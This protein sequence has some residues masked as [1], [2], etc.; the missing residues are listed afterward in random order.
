MD[1]MGEEPARI[2]AELERLRGRVVDLE[3]RLAACRGE[4]EP[5]RPELLG[6]E[7]REWLLSKTEHLTRMGSFVWEMSN[8]ATFWSDELYRILGYEVG[9]LTP[10]AE[11]FFAIVHPDDREATR[12]LMMAATAEGVRTDASFRL[13]LR[14]GTIKHARSTAVPVVGTSGNVTSFVGAVIDITERV[15]A[16]AELRR[17]EAF[18]EEAQKIAHVGAFEWYPATGESTSSAGL[19][20]ICGLFPDE[21]VTFER[22][23]ELVHPDDRAALYELATGVEPGQPIPPHEY[24]IV[25]PDGT[26]VHAYAEGSPQYDAEGRPHGFIGAVLDITRRKAL[27]AQLLQSQK[28][29]A[30]GRLAGGV[31]HDFNNL[32]TVIGVHVALL[33]RRRQD[34]ELDEVA[35]A[36]ERAGQLTRQLLAFSRQSVFELRRVE[37]VELVR[38]S[39]RMVKRIVGEDVEIGFEAEPDVGAVSVDPSQLEQVLLNLVVNSR[40]ALPLGGHVTVRVEKARLNEPL[41]DAQPALAP[42]EYVVLEVADDGIGMD[43]EVRIRALEPFF[44]TKEPGRGTG[45]GL[46][47]VFGIVS[48]SG[49]GITLD[50]SKGVGT[51][52]RVYLPLAEAEAVPSDSDP[53]AEAMRG[54]GELLLL[55]DDDQTLGRLLAQVLED[56]G[57]RVHRTA[58]GA[59]AL[60]FFE[61]HQDEVRLVVTD[62]VMPEIGGPELVRRLRA[63]RPSLPALYVSG[64]ARESP[65][66]DDPTTR[67]AFL[68]KP[69]TPTQLI[70][71]VVEV[72]ARAR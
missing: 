38:N 8:G 34:R 12:E 68:M 11:A 31:A 19:S 25:R 47:M 64:Y 28:M 9:E 20:R 66:D 45:L 60:E 3:S 72:L 15:E 21:K 40:D 41:A 67:G 7:A 49:G 2:R 70:R 61:S 18:L 33:R 54:A 52:V 27:E 57:Y 1:D 29:E 44:T 63:R 71:R 4:P 58:T 39:L 37:P 50:S 24:R 43:E 51:T 62:V 10:S 53:G 32:L 35:G 26:V 30:L 6:V 48:Q 56:A 69:F 16:E 5:P 55:I 14:D 59:A 36:V 13:L 65:R 42:G 22:L 17:R 23:L 46:A